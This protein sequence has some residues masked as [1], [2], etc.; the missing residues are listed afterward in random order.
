MKTD[1]D[2]SSDEELMRAYQDGLEKAFQILY[3][4]HSSKVYGFLINRIRDKTLVDDI[5]QA[6]FMKLHESRRHYDPKF[7]FIPWLFT[8]SRSV[9]IDSLRKQK[10]NLEDS[11]E[12][13]KLDFLSIEY[14]TAE[15][16]DLSC[17]HSNQKQAVELRYKENLSFEEIAHQLKTTP[18]N[19]R[20][21]VS[22]AIKVLKKSFQERGTR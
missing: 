21:I 20:K 7:S 12:T 8:I 18:T 19:V 9:M 17:L 1:F 2:S 6:I 3:H 5:F 22:R 4:R 15:E 11:V 16:L 13:D 10:R 14:E